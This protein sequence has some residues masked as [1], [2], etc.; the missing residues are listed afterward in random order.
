MPSKFLKASMIILIGEFVT[1]FLGFLYLAPLEKINPEIGTVSA[2][3]MQPYSFFLL[4]VILGVS[5][6]LIAEFTKYY[7]KDV[8]K[9]KKAFMD[10]AYYLLITSSLV[11]V[12]LFVFAGPLIN[13]YAGDVSYTNQLVDGM[14]ILSISVIF[15]GFNILMKSKLLVHGHYK[16]V[17]ISYI[18]EQLIKIFILLGGAIWLYYFNDYPIGISAYLISLSV[19]ISIVFTSL[20]F[21]V[22][23]YKYQMFA[24]FKKIEYQFKFS[25]LKKLF[26]LGVIFFVNGLFIVGFQQIDLSNFSN[27][28]LSKG[29]SISEKNDY[30]GIY[31]TWSWKLIMFPVTLGSVLITMMVKHVK[32]ENENKQVVIFNQIFNIVIVYSII[33]TIFFLTG[34]QYFYNW[35]YGPTEIGV[36]ILMT[37][38]LLIPLFIIRTIMTVYSLIQKSTKIILISTFIM[39]MVKIILNP[40]LFDIFFINGYIYSSIIAIIISILILLVFDHKTYA[41]NKK[42][43]YEKSMIVF[44]MTILLIVSL[45]FT[46]L[47]TQVLTSDFF[48]F[49][50]IGLFIVLITALLY[51]KYLKIKINQLF[52]GRG[53]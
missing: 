50:S 12:I 27:D 53:I 17:S 11:M 20:I 21:L 30:L 25:G 6:I 35:F 4:F 34:G 36:I 29:Y 40:I 48:L 38:S 51:I 23:A 52:K 13:S 44:K 5:N 3:L 28:V 22:T 9:Y 8:I 43:I 39:F 46:N 41:V 47:I 15:F 33:V 14:R 16:I 32:L 10:G 2:L 45:G 31:F 1:R 26:L 24:G 7:Q 19:T 42:F 18:F 37:Q 49:S